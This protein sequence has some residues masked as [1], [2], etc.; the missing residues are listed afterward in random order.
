MK[1]YLLEVW[2]CEAGQIIFETLG[3]NLP[4]IVVANDEAGCTVPSRARILL[5]EKH[6]YG[7]PLEVQWPQ[8]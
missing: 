4:F 2:R 6:G 5:Q 3:T 1:Q 8:P 7:G